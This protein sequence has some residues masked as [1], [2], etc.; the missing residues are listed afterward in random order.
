MPNDPIAVAAEI[1][2][3]AAGRTVAFT[4]AGMS[5][6]SG[7][8]TYR[9]ATKG[10]VDERL[11]TIS[12]RS[13][14]AYAFAFEFKRLR[15]FLIENGRCFVGARPNAGHEALAALEANG[16]VEA[17]ITQ[18]V[19][20]L[21]RAAGSSDVLELHG[22]Y[23]RTRCRRCGEKRDV[24]RETI[25]ALIDR[26]HDE[27]LTRRAFWRAFSAHGPRCEACGTLG[28]PDMVMF[29]EP[30][31]A[32]IYDRAESL[33][34]GCGALLAVGTTVEVRPANDIPF[35][36]AYEGAPIVEVN[37]EETA[38]T[39]LAEVSIRGTSAEVLPK[40]VRAAE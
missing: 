24:S 35:I 16:L 10:Q 9:G 37:P 14:L 28:R 31:D 5:E 26:L 1:L 25:G 39:A 33:A 13:G 29:G 20:D 23:F 19:D 40:L 8:P 22:N 3:S 15:P 17:V 27:G 30:L 6:E 34:A 32:T 2:R 36:A 4:G 21:H 12:R 38:L 18:N 7:I 11:P